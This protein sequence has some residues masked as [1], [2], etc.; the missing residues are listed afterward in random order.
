ME[1]FNFEFKHKCCLL[2]F[3]LLHNFPLNLMPKIK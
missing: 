3:Q 2:N 1:V